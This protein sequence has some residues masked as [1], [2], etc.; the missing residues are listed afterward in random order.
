VLRADAVNTSIGV[1]VKK[2]V[3]ARPEAQKID[4]PRRSKPVAPA[5]RPTVTDAP[6]APA[7]A[8]SPRER[9]ER[10]AHA[11]R[12][13]TAQLNK[14]PGWALSQEEEIEPAK[15]VERGEVLP[16]PEK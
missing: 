2:P 10:L 13:P 11:S 4:A 14:E 12:A 5:V 6:E 9:M 16:A 8:L 7:K 3:D 15:P 1:A